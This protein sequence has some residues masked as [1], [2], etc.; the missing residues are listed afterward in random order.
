MGYK[1][2]NSLQCPACGGYHDS[3]Y[4]CPN[5]EIERS[6]E[7]IEAFLFIKSLSES[8]KESRSTP[9]VLDIYGDAIDMVLKRDESN[10]NTKWFKISDVLPNHGDFVLAYSPTF[11][12]FESKYEY[13]TWH[14]WA[15]EDY[16]RVDWYPLGDLHSVTHWMPWPREPLIV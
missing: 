10:R 5:I 4:L 9:I 11:G 13:G 2:N 7:E 3:M 14:V 8:I 16:E 12:R 6:G 15:C 1:M